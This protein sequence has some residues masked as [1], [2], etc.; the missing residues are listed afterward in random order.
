LPSLQVNASM[1][2]D[3]HG[4]LYLRDTGRYRWANSPS[5]AR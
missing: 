2:D 3:D 1:V 5:G 4:R